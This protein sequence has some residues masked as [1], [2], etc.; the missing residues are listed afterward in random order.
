MDDAP[1]TTG[2]PHPRSRD[3]GIDEIPLPHGPGRLWLCGKHVV[4]PDPE[5]VLA[6]LGATTIVCLTRRHELDQRFPDYVAWL[7]DHVDDR[8]VWFPID[9]LH[10]PSL[11]AVE[12]FVADV[13]ARLDRGEGIVMHCA[14]GIGRA[15]TVAT[16]VLIALGLDVDAALSVVAANRPMAGPEVGAQRELVLAFKRR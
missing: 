13:A 4:G 3:G 15:G 14:A 16:C 8:A 11:G 10:A 12:S 2:W 1:A 5:R 7:D 6:A 9:D